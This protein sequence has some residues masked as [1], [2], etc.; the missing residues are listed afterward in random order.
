MNEEVVIAESFQSK[1]TNQR[2]KY[3]SPCSPSFLRIVFFALF[4]SFS[5]S[6]PSLC[7][8]DTLPKQLLAASSAAFIACSQGFVVAALSRYIKIPTP[9]HWDFAHLSIGRCP[10]VYNRFNYTPF[11]DKKT[12]YILK[13]L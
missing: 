7:S 11:C 6:T 12:G 8:D 1:E 10:L 9:F 13:F 4:I 2:I 5:D 3:I